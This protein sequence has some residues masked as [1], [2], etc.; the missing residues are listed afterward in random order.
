MS[1][2][3]E[4]RGGRLEW[5]GVYGAGIRL[6]AGWPVEWTVDGRPSGLAGT[7]TALAAW[8]YAVES[9]HVVGPLEVVQEVTALDDLAAVPSIG[10]S[11]WFR[12]AATEPV[13]VRLATGLRPFLAPVLLEGIKPYGYTLSGRPDQVTVTSHGFG[14][15]LHA[16]PAPTRWTVDGAPWNGD[17]REGEITGC[18]L[19]FDLEVPPQGSAAVHWVLAG[20]FERYLG[21][22]GSAAAGILRA[23]TGWTDQAA[24]RFDGW[25]A[26]TPTMSLPGLPEV[27]RAY[28]LARGAV[29]RLYHRPEPTIT[30]LVAGYPWYSAIWGRDLAWILPAVLWLGDADWVAESLRSILRFQAATAVPLLGGSAGEVPMQ[31]GAGPLFLYG[32]SDTTLYYP[33]LIL[34]LVEH[35]GRSD[36]AAEFTGPLAAIDRWAAAKID[37]ASGL[38]TH[39]G[40]V[41]EI[42]SATGSAGRVHFG[43]DAYDTTIW[44]STDRRDHAIDVQVLYLRALRSLARLAELM[45]DAPAFQRFMSAA[46]DLGRRLPELYAWAE[47]SYLVDSRRL[48]GTPVRKLRPNALRA[49][50]DGLLAP[51]LAAAVS[52]R[53]ARDDLATGWGLRTLGSADPAYD[54]QAYHDGQVWPIATAWAI[55]AAFAAGRP[56]AGRRYLLQEARRLIAER[57]LS[58]ECYRGDR[59]EP[60]DA[61]FLLG[62]SVAPFVTALFRRLWGIEPFLLERTV[63][64]EPQLPPASEPSTLQG[65]RLAEG[66][67]DL[68]VGDGQVRVV[69]RGTEP[70]DV[71]SEEARVRVAPKVPTS[72]ELPSGKPS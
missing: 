57:G 60:Y 63:R 72:I 12:S 46:T 40:E 2:A 67:L 32:T 48:D 61:C 20:G 14:A 45:G 1:L 30:G 29:R 47:E 26:T 70:I 15:A 34:D 58:A 28:D 51:P 50:A 36:L 4:A 35:T 43:F 65:L 13:R 64:I 22:S 39:G 56:E 54:P 9:H 11:L 5:G 16:D 53:A 59:P 62:F 25:V 68:T 66:T 7:M 49:V 17:R 21:P 19:E 23:A 27:A 44:D 18:G 10:R 3:R 31:F 37:P 55:D 41:A 6:T 71:T 52:D 33:T 42:R 24:A 69:W 38:F 8:P